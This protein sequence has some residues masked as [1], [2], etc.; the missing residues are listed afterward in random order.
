MKSQFNVVR[1]ALVGAAM[2]VANIIPGVSGGTIA[3]VFGIYEYL[4]EALGNF[5]TDK[6][7]RWEYIRFLAVLFLGTLLSIAVFARVLKMAFE[8]FPLPTI[9][10]F[11]GLIVGSIPVVI[12]SHPDMKLNTPRAFSFILGMVLVVVLALLQGGG[13]AAVAAP[14]SL[15]DHG[16]GYY[17]YLVICGIVAASAMIVPGV[18][19]SFILILM[20][21]Y[22]TVLSAVSGFV[23]L[24][25]SSGL[26]PEV[27]IR[28]KIIFAILIGVVAGILIF[29]RIMS[30]ALTKFPAKTMYAILGLIVGSIYQ[31][32]PGFL[33][34]ISGLTSIITMVAGLLISLKFSKTQ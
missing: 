30:W 23:T 6:Q 25:V 3:V 18:S 4:M 10:F 2:G 28:I 14:T 17:A 13:E 33:F 29:S 31:I 20:G 9:Y 12:K 11:I 19:G 27:M 15:V 24:L 1:T 22:W 26:T 34:D 32:Y 5:I 16:I 21:T 8:F 7:K